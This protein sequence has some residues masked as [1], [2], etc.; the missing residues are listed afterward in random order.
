M[1][2]N[3]FVSCPQT[4]EKLCNGPLANLTNGFCDWL[5]EQGFSHGTIYL[6]L[7]NISRLNDYLAQRD[8]YPLTTVSSLDIESFFN[9][10]FLPCN[11]GA[12]SANHFRTIHYAVSRFIDYLKQQN[13]FIDKQQ[14]PLF[15]PLLDAYLL[16]LRVHQHLAE[17]SIKLRRLYIA[18]LLSWLG[19]QATVDGLSTLTSSQV[20]TFFL[21]DSKKL[22]KAGRRSLQAA[23]RT[24]FR[25]CFQQDY[26][27]QRLDKAVPT[28]RTYQLASVPRAIDD[29]A[30][31]KVLCSIDQSTSVGKRD[32]AIIMLLYTLGL[33][34]G[35]LAALRLQDI[36]WAKAQ[37]LIKA[38]KNGKSTVLPLTKAVGDALFSY[39]RDARP[40]STCP[41]VFLTSRAPY[42]SLAHSRA[43]GQIVS[44]HI[45]QSDINSPTKGT[46]Q[47][48]HCFASRM[49]AQGHPLNAVADVLG[50][51]SLSNT[52]IYTKVDFQ[53]LKQVALEWPQ[54][55]STC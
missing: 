22:Q 8:P 27:K 1:L 36:N 29:E 19:P 50:H 32:H 43:I 26:I 4:R 9:N 33:R 6:H 53:T 30:A 17:S 21:T 12:V 15:Q 14:Q 45:I 5:N 24:F 20:E 35:Q 7:L 47:F 37:I 31:R 28:L 11:N 25:F 2:L 54:E 10:Y 48:R 55:V 40:D 3:N 23:L 51:R 39:I 52:F 18:H 34:A 46:H 49:V 16:W 13:C 41:E 38:A 44:S 42:R